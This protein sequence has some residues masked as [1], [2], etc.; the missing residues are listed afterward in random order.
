MKR[1][2]Y[3]YTLLIFVLISCSSNNTVVETP[4]QELKHYVEKI[5]TTTN[6][7]ASELLFVY[8]DNN[9]LIRNQSSQNGVDKYYREFTY[10]GDNIVKIESITL[11]NTPYYTIKFIYDSSNRVVEVKRDDHFSNNLFY[12]TYQYDSKDRI[13]RACLYTNL[14][15]YNKKEC[16]LYYQFSYIGNTKNY[17]SKTLIQV[18]IFGAEISE[19]SEWNFDNNKRP[20]FGEAIKKIQLPYATDGTGMDYE[21][22]YNTN[23]P[24]SKEM[25]VD[26]NTNLKKTRLSF[27]YEY[28]E[29]GFPSQMIRNKFNIVSGA[30]SST[31][32]QGFNYKLQ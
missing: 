11:P 15:D 13:S 23:N 32:I 22:M 28:N 14:D 21:F 8:D 18:S 9:N 6:N 7:G 30:L 10:E 24:K 16:N 2:V 31:L 19:V 26:F 27:D 5:I 4:D 1:L 12:V 17:F 20:Y 29:E 3:S 25:I